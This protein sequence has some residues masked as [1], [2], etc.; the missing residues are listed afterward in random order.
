M[1]RLCKA[2]FLGVFFACPM[3]GHAQTDDVYTPKIIPPSP[4]AAS[5]MK[6]GDIPVS[7]Y[8]GSA[9]VT[10]PI[11]TIQNGDISVPI[12]LSYNSTGIR[13]N[14]EASWV[15][16]G[17]ALSSGGMISRSIMDKNDFDGGYFN[18]N[19]PEITKTPASHPVPS[20]TTIQ[21]NPYMYDFWCN[22]LIY[23][24][25]DTLNYTTALTG[26]GIYDLEADVY[27]YNFPGF[28]GKFIIGRNG[29]PIIQNQDNL[30]I[31]Y[32]SN[33]GSFTITDD[34]GFRY[35]F[36]SKEYVSRDVATPISSWYLSQ[37][38]SPQGRTVQFNYKE[39]STWM[40]VAGT[41]SH[42][43]RDACTVSS[44]ITTI[45]TA[46]TTYK[47]ITLESIDFANGTVHFY[48]DNTR[49]DQTNGKRLNKVSV[50]RKN[51]A[52][53]ST[54]IFSYNLYYSYFNN[55]Y[56]G[57]ATEFKR[58]RLDSVKQSNGSTFLPP[59]KFV[60]Y[61]D[62]YESTNL[63]GKSSFSIDHWGYY[64]GATNSY[65]FPKFYGY[66]NTPLGVS[67]GQP[68]PSWW[69][70]TEGGDRHPKN[71]K[72]QLFSLNTVVY[73]TG[74]KSVF[75]LEGNDYDENRSF[76]QGQ[77]DYE[78][79]NYYDTSVTYT[80][81]TRG[82]VN[83]S[84]NFL[85]KYGSKVKVNLAFRCS[86]GTAATTLHGTT[87]QIYVSI[88]GNTI[89]INSGSLTLSGGVVWTTGEVEY[90]VPGNSVSNWSTYINPSITTADFQDIT[91]TIRW[92]ELKRN[93]YGVILGGGLR[94]KSITDYNEA[95]VA[96]K[97]RKYDY[98]YWEDRDSNG[99][100]EEYSYGRLIS[101]PSY[102]RYEILRGTSQDG[103]PTGCISLTR[104]GTSVI[105]ITGVTSGNSVGYDQVTEYVVDPTNESNTL[106]KT[107]YQYH[108]L[109]DTIIYYNRMRLPGVNS[110]GS[111]KNGQLKAKIDYRLT[112][113]TYYKV[114]ETF[115]YYSVG[116]RK[117]IYNM[118]LDNINPQGVKDLSSCAPGSPG[119]SVEYLAFIYPA[120][121]S[122]KILLDSTN[123]IT[124]ESTGTSNFLSSTTKNTYT[125]TTT[126]Q[127][128]SKTEVLNSKNE[129]QKTEIYYPYD[130]SGAVY[131]SM[132]AR[133]MVSTV[134][135]QKMYTNSTLMS[136][137]KTQFKLW[138]SNTYIF[139]D[140]VAT[141]TLSNSLEAA[142]RFNEYDVYGN[143]IQYTGR[144]GLPVSFLWDYN[145]SYPIAKVT[146]APITS[147]AYTSFES[148]NNGNWIINDA[149]RNNEAVTGERSF[150]MHGSNNI[151][152]TNSS[153]NVDYYISYW[154]KTGQLTVGGITSLATKT[155]LTKNGW[156]YY[157]H[158]VR[159]TG[160][161][162]TLSSSSTN[163]LDELRLHPVTAQMET[164]TYL[165]LVGTTSQCSVN[166]TIVYYV[167]D[168]F[169]RLRMIR[170]ADGNILK[171]MEYNYRQ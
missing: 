51:S 106:G 127:Q 150:I 157:E 89:D 19:V 80:I 28:S 68:Q 26:A 79:I 122:E 20:V 96:V 46:A 107:V 166:N 11:Y 7:F 129:W 47:N 111:T 116:N 8:T 44:G 50:F 66:F 33:A 10:V 76:I 115:N 36:N 147:I 77:T 86:N 164:F 143:T 113:G 170:D 3:F 91:V 151:V 125:P 101:R 156:T 2:F 146:N 15:G 24:T 70:L 131:D 55:S 45:T 142:I 148:A 78:E 160:T 75:E 67:P 92:K 168:A 119:V 121:Q 152:Y 140:S 53:D 161:N 109:P 103:W 88:M 108:N 118:K 38:T 81:S 124:Y 171:T 64:N 18:S 100:P 32:T 165:P 74:G 23:T 59:Y 112:S 145:N 65:L 12:N 62:P 5:L 84:V 158:K 83:N 144:N 30:K 138:Q 133:N 136:Q 97:K 94:I 153:T 39:E 167:Y 58:L 85:N 31:E 4:T 139:P 6:F 114:A 105:G 98:H 134:I 17:W 110:I 154:S 130:Y 169:N 25:G 73:P 117:M 61:E 126:Y 95:N 14:E 120:I 21:L 27:S 40:T 43:V 42:T 104:F 135:G 34:K 99:T 60:Y 35:F 9:G 48:F 90:T 102:T 54:E 16:L 162:I 128:L 37:I 87:S 141:A 163:I 52:I 72:P 137:V 22:Y 159:T 82:T 93:T 41:A 69:D 132:M 123:Q 13:L 57:T 56:G 63:T 29:V 155:G 149:T 49:T 1:N 71:L